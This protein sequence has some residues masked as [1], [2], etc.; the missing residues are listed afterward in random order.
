[1]AA[2]GLRLE[3]VRVDFPG[4]RALDEVSLRIEPGEAVGLVG[5]SG[6]GKTTLLRLLNGS[7]RVTSGRVWVNGSA[8]DSL[9][10]TELRRVR[11]GIGFIHQDLCLIPNIRVAQNVVAGQLGQMSL[12]RSLREM[13]YP[14]RRLVERVYALLE[15]VGIG[16][17]IFERTDRLSGG[18]MQ[19]V[20][21]ARALFQ[22][23]TALL[24]DEPVS[25]VDPA[26]AR[27]TVDL[28][29]RISRE[30]RLTLCVSLHSLELA[31]AYLPRLIGIRDGRVAFD[32]ASSEIHDDEFAA[33][34]DL[35]SG[36][37]EA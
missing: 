28:L 35:N 33:L 1:M 6:A 25:S 31:R 37:P 3:K 7:Q 4:G 15:R 34:Y 36:T 19:R 26:R 21:V 17:K 8:L 14:S 30:D 18:Q 12:A 9:S 24:A 13:V 22:E 23:P 11:A 27:D 20:A 29:V 16:E 32:R 10:R 5:P 2:S